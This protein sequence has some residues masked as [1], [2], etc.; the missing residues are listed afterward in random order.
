MMLKRSITKTVEKTAK[1]EQRAQR[2][3]RREAGQKKRDGA[4]KRK[5][6][7]GGKKAVKAAEKK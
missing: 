7:R 2:H 3:S 1:A 6:E 5:V 4:F